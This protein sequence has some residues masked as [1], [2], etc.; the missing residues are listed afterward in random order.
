MLKKRKGVAV[1][2]LVSKLVHGA[3]DIGNIPSV[4]WGREHEFQAKKAF[5]ETEGP[6]HHTMK[7]T[8]TGLIIDHANPILAATPDG[9]IR[10]ECCL[11][12]ILEIKC[13]YNIREKDVITAWEQTDFLEQDNSGTINLK[14]NHRYFAQIQ[15]QMAIAKVKRGYFTVWTTIGQPLVSEI[16][17]DYNF[18]STLQEKLVL[19]FKRYMLKVVSGEDQLYFCSLCSKICLEPDEITRKLDESV[20]CDLCLLWYHLRCIPDADKVCAEVDW[21]CPLCRSDE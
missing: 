12:A 18:W 13:P 1:R 11:P 16:Q 15:G 8:E 19:F 9:L 10:C 7:V 17:F 5:V 4:K 6:K 20:Q 21:H 14:R 3:P 2:P